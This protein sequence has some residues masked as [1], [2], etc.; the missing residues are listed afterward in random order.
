MPEISRIPVI[1]ILCP[2][3]CLADEIQ[4]RRLL[5][6]L[7]YPGRELERLGAMRSVSARR[8]SIAA[9]L[10]A[11]RAMADYI[12]AAEEECDPP[13]AGRLVCMDRMD[14]ISMSP[15][16]DSW[17]SMWERSAEGKPRVRRAPFDLSLSHTDRA[18]VCALTVNRGWQIGVDME[19]FT[20]A[21]PTWERLSDRVLSDRE[22]LKVRDAPSFLNVWTRKEAMGKALGCGMFC[23]RKLDT[24]SLPETTFSH[25]VWEDS[26]ITVCLMPQTEAGETRPR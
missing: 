5:M 22:R 21:L 17:L 16:L 6:R 14:N 4:A 13:D 25:F 2:L 23:A 11:A 1:L 15:R 24:M 18:A 12:S 9:R 8:Q 26:D 7:G 20:R 10:A 3:S 19:C